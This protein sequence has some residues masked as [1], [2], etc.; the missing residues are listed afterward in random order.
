MLVYH[1]SNQEVSDPQADWNEGYAERNECLDYGVGFYLTFDKDKAM[2]WAYR[3]VEDKGGIATLNFY[4]IDDCYDEDFSYLCFHDT[5]EEW[6]N[7]LDHCR[8]GEG[9]YQSE[10]EIIEGQVADDDGYDIFKDVQERRIDIDYAIEQLSDMDLGFQVCLRTQR[11]IDA[12]LS[13]LNSEE[14]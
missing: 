5:N 1:G 3:A 10:Y 2:E 11:V 13:F 14:I 4:D 7:F 9:Y 12:Y 8:R 6:Y